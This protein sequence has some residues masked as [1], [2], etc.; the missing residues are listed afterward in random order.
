[1]APLRE[2]RP[3]LLVKGR[4]AEL[5]EWPIERTDLALGPGFPRSVGFRFRVEG[6]RRG[7]TLELNA[8]L[9][10]E[11]QLLHESTVETPTVE[12]SFIRQLE[13]AK[14]IAA[15]PDSVAITCWESSHNPIGRAKVLYDIVSTCRP[16]VL[17]AYSFHEFGA[18]VWEPL[19][20]ADV[21]LVTIPWPYREVYHELLADAGM[22]FS[23][24]WMCKPR[25]PTFELAAHVA[26]PDARVILD[27]DDNEEH[28]SLSEAST[29]KPYGLP[30]IG[31][32][33]ALTEAVPSRTVASRSLQDAFGGHLVRHA[34]VGQRG[35]E[36][37]T[38]GEGKR[39]GFIGTVRR[40]KNL[41]AAAQAV[42]MTRWVHKVDVELHVL[43][44]VEPDTLC[45]ELREHGAVVG[46]VVPSSELAG[47]IE[48]LDCVLTGFPNQTVDFAEIT[49]F[50]ISS[51]IGD[52][53]A[54]GIPAL[55][56]YGESVADL[57]GVPGVYLFR[58][59]T[60]PDVLMAAMRHQGPIELPYEF[61][62]RGAYAAFA[63]AEE[64]AGRSPRAGQALGLVRKP[65]ARPTTI[66][67][68]GQRNLLLLWKQ[69]DA[70]LYGRRIDQIA[71]AY[72]TAFP[73]A[74][75]T[76]LE[77]MD[78]SR[79]NTL[80]GIERQADH[81]GDGRLI[82]PL[83][84]KKAAGGYVDAD[85]V[86]Y[87]VLTLAADEAVRR[88]FEGWLAAE[89]L[90][91]ANTTIVHFPILPWYERLHSTLSAYPSIV[92]VVDNQFSWASSDTAM[93]G[94]AWQYH[95]MLRSADAICF[96]SAL[97]RQHFDQLGMLG[98]P[99]LVSQIENWY[100][101]P[102]GFTTPTGGWLGAGQHVM[103]SGN[104]NDRVDWGLLLRVAALPGQPRIHLV[105]TAARTQLQTL[106]RVMTHDQVVY[107]GP[108][109]E[110]ETLDLLSQADVAIM[111]H[112]V[113][114]FSTF[115]NPLKLSMYE[116]LGL[117]VVSTDVPGVTA[118]E[119]MVHVVGERKPFVRTVAALLDKAPER[120]ARRAT[121]VAR[122]RG[123]T[124]NA[125][126]YVDMIDRVG[127]DAS[128]RER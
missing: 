37:P 63:T 3:V 61:T 6:A 92:D 26:G 110:L 125:Q 50:Q 104:M 80:R 67:P 88:Q 93:T 60:F 1:M 86:E 105:G 41:L 77:L 69:Q 59:A 38:G 12:R 122:V 17:F 16:A 23:T 7:D 111:P 109:N 98:A 44:D 76:V 87:R 46:G 24:V 27:L 121:R 128:R 49:R 14:E 19:V 57:E 79:W 94:Y 56:P 124:K 20:D 84:E 112:K 15:R 35:R 2:M 9:G 8:L 123:T 33:R 102:S 97:N 100:Q 74:R 118:V 70:G 10:T 36:L 47:Q 5:L 29:R 72:R 117:P 40:H 4:A 53:L 106:R 55:V 73:D 83:L 42:A 11:L 113:D 64:M 107:H 85:G 58:E 75:V 65:V 91:P 22:D 52:A 21:E 126:A 89:G 81:L 48:Q 82:L 45:A 43:G 39:V 31:L 66:S 13:R 103:Y 34:R 101:P 127:A 25:Y 28:F 30:G 115:M 32:G 51:K 18:T 90:T 99:D 62:L 68:R 116:A 96:N 71:R 54:S 119:G 120:R 114:E 78:A 95:V 108:R